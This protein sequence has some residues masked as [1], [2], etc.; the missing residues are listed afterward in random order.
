MGFSND[1]KWTEFV[2]RRKE[3]IPSERTTEMEIIIKHLVRSFPSKCWQSVISVTSYGQK[4]IRVV[5][6][7]ILQNMKQTKKSSWNR[8]F[9]LFPGTIENAVF[10]SIIMASNMPVAYSQSFS[11]LRHGRNFVHNDSLLS[12]FP[13]TCWQKIK[14]S[15]SGDTHVSSTFATI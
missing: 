15:V 11:P 2:M 1:P 12:R 5:H 8:W 10:E 9:K 4:A 13:K 6:G 7:W 14:P 3:L